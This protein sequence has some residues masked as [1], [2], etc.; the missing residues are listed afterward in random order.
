MG[1]QKALT[2]IQFVGKLSKMGDRRIIYIPKDFHK[3]AEKLEGKQIYVIA[4]DDIRGKIKT[5]T[6]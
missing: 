1:I 5:P 4:T 3:E 2:Q 6:D